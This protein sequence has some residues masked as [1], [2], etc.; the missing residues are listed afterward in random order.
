MKRRDLLLTLALLPLLRPAAQAAGPLRQADCGWMAAW[1]HFSTHFMQADGRI[2]DR[3]VGEGI[4]TSEGQAY[5]AFFA[6][7]ADDRPRFEAILGW[8]RANL[9]GG[10]FSSRLMA[11]KWGK[12][13]DQQW[14][15]LDANPASDADLWLAY[16]LFE[17]A[18]LWQHRPYHATALQICGRLEHE[19]IVDLAGIGPILLPGPQG[20]ALK[21]GGWRVN[22]SYQP[23]FLLRG[24]AREI[25]GG[26][27]QGLIGSTMALLQAVTV[28]QLAPD[29]AMVTPR[30]GFALEAEAPGAYDAIRV[31]LWAGM[32]AETDPER[33]RLL[34]QLRGILSAEARPEGL[35][36]RFDVRTGKGEGRAG[37]GLSI[38]LLPYFDALATP[39]AA[40]AAARIRARFAAQPLPDIYY[41]QVL[42]LFATGY[43]EGR[44]RFARDGRLL[45]E[46]GHPCPPR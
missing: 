32:T 20:F 41:D 21:G 34:A 31:Y 38:A 36:E 42:S 22:P 7:V 4:S 37:A 10:D 6:L 14:G 2:I 13:A 35:P 8:A 9:A 11:W 29:W 43:S 17:A 23:L 24:L 12:R 15:V 46:K 28:Q 19:V 30:Q 40:T 44:Y 5:A 27:W 3:S 33:P 25:P 26:P 45:R 39:A 1:Q 16:T 18:R